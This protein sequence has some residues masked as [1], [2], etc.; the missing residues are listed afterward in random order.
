MFLVWPH[1]VLVFFLSLFLVCVLSVLRLVFVMWFAFRFAT[2]R[3]VVSS[4]SCSR[5]ATFPRVRVLIY[6]NSDLFV[7]SSRTLKNSTLSFDK[8]FFLRSRGLALG[9]DYSRHVVC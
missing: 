8:N 6:K 4:C 3:L 1:L 2:L 7:F 9:K 5:T